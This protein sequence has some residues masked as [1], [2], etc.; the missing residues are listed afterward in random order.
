[1]QTTT[2][3]IFN[4]NVGDNVRV[5]SCEKCPLIVDKVGTVKEI[6]ENGIRVSFGKGRPPK[7]R[8]EFFNF[9]DLSLVNVD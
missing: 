4:F 9:T 2:E 5:V 6:T 3:A 8:P 1:M 7:G